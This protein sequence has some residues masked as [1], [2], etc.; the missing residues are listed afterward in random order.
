MKRIIALVLCLCL[1][2]CLFAG[3]RKSTDESKNNT[4]S[5]TDGSISAIAADGKLDG[6]EYGLGAKIADV[7]A[8]YE[9]L[10]NEYEENHGDDDHDHGLIGEES[11]YY[12]LKE[13]EG[14]NIIDVSSARFYYET[15]N[16]AKGVLVIASDSD[17]F[18]FNVGI[19]TK[20][21]VEEAVNAKGKT[22][23]ATEAELRF[24]NVRTEPVLVLRYEFDDYNLDF[25]FNDNLLITTVIT[26]TEN[27]TI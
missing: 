12:A 20:Y 5:S 1:T 17:T 19:T 14:Y 18:G 13:K 2:A 26:D 27:W 3:C 11:H 10:A 23:N 8:H 16:E 21:E 22:F 25:Y 4:D 6:V 7:K 15:D 24:L 9:A